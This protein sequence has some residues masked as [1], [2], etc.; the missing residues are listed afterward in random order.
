[1]SWNFSVR[2]KSFSGLNIVIVQVQAMWKSSIHFPYETR[3]RDTK[4][5]GLGQVKGKIKWLVTLCHSLV[6]LLLCPRVPRA[7]CVCLRWTVRYNHS[8]FLVPA[9]SSTEL[10]SSGDNRASV[11]LSDLS[12]E[13]FIKVII[14]FQPQPRVTAGGRKCHH[15]D[16]NHSA[17]LSRV[18]LGFASGCPRSHWGWGVALGTGQVQ[19]Q[20]GIPRGKI[21]SH[22]TASRVCLNSWVCLSSQICLNS[23]I[24]LTSQVCLSSQICLRSV[25][26]LFQKTPKPVKSHTLQAVDTSAQ[27]VNAWSLWTLSWLQ[28]VA[29]HTSSASVPV[30]A[31]CCNSVLPSQFYERVWIAPPQK[32]SAPPALVSLFTGWTGRHSGGWLDCIL[33]YIRG[34]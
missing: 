15:S 5:K 27:H 34:L 7:P 26:R 23:Q 17:A 33:S 10:Q 12:T 25:L 28:E 21:P 4:E 22:F 3:A 16:C 31:L 11:L 32:T 2:P 13:A 19:V 8:H 30:A 14:L 24:C 6:C 18:E 20:M 1:M 29:S 9:S